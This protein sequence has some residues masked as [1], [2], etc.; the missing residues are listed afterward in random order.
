MQ[1][2]T[3][4][5]LTPPP[6]SPSPRRYARKI[7]ITLLAPLVLLL[8]GMAVAGGLHIKDADGYFGLVLLV[9]CASSIAG[10]TMIC[11]AA[12][13]SILARIVIFALSGGLL[14]AF[15]TTCIFS[16]CSAVSGPMNFH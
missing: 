1:P 12:T 3:E 10:A 5:P 6:P 13:E 4:P 16:G 9:A 14:I 15:Y 2:P 8:L 7:W 11:M